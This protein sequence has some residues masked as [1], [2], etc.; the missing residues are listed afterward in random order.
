MPHG[1]IPVCWFGWS[2]TIAK[3]SIGG[4]LGWWFDASSDDALHFW[5]LRHLPDGSLSSS[6]LRHAKDFL[7]ST[8]DLLSGS[9]GNSCVPCRRLLV[10][11][12][13]TSH[14]AHRTSLLARQEIFS[15]ARLKSPVCRTQAF[16][17]WHTRVLGGDGP[18]SK[19]PMKILVSTNSMP[20]LSNRLQ[21]EQDD[22]R[23]TDTPK[24]NKNQRFWFENWDFEL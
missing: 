7:N 13:E 24:N 14:L 16:F 6:L 3:H 11:R 17:T 15:V 12:A 21:H 19:G 8:R 2:L 5:W 9:C 20:C 10:Y 1:R 22:G 23:T 4:L 18:K